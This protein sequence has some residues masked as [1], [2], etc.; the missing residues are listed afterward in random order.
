MYG[1]LVCDYKPHKKR[2]RTR[3]AHSGG[4]QARLVWRYDN[5]HCVHH[6]IQ[7]HHQHHSLNRRQGHDDMINITP[8]DEVH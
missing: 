8:S 7:N 5:L 1:K 3:Q 6:N 4:L 2:K